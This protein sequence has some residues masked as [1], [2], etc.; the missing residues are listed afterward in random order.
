MPGT[1]IGH[2]MP[3]SAG[4]FLRD[5][6]AA[7]PARAADGFHQHFGI[8]DGMPDA[9]RAIKQGWMRVNKGLV[10]N[11][12]GF[13]GQEQRYV[14]VLLTEQPVDADFDTGQKAVTAG[15]EALAPV[16]ATDM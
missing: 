2:H 12:T 16:L 13:V 10:L 4:E 1:D 8:P 11:T 9:E 6:L 5:A 3:P 7:A 15:I 14:V